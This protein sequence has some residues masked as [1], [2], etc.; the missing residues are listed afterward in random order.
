MK[1]IFIIGSIFI[2]IFVASMMTPMQVVAISNGETEAIEVVEQKIKFVFFHSN[3]CPHCKDEQK[4]IE[5]KLKPAYGEFVEF[6]EYEISDPENQKIFAQYGRLYNINISGVPVT[7]IG[8][9]VVYGYGGDKSTG[10]QIKSIIEGKLPKDFQNEDN[11]GQCSSETALGDTNRCVHVPIL[12]NVDAKT[13]SLPLLTMV[14]GL[15]DGFNPCAMW[16]L[17]FL[18]SLLLGIEDRRRM[19]ILGGLFILSSGIVYFMFMAAWLKFLMFIGMILAVRI[20][21]GSVAVGVGAWNLRDYWK[22]RK[23]DGAVCKVSKNTG[24]KNIF[25]KIKDI[26]YKK[27][28]LW[29]IIGIIILGFSVNLVELACSAG[30]PAVFTQVLALSEITQWKRYMYM[31]GYILFYMLDDMIIFGIAMITL[32]SKTVGGSY[33]KYAN[34]IGGLLIFILGILLIFKPAW[35]TLG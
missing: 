29:S 26:V 3:T 35:V 33:A 18:I 17:V 6:K 5:K 15:L 27:S 13:F 19:W 2:S 34:L 14:V 24:A 11:R 20:I 9:Q 23:A 31:A 22:N 4:F 12:G 16:T 25:D 32:K 21:I 30:F 7:F 10:E 28:L 8:D 1:K